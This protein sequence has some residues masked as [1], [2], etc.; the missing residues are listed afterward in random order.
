MTRPGDKIPHDRARSA[1]VVAHPDDEVLWFSGVLGQVQRIVLCFETIATYPQ[2]TA[3]RKRVLGRYPIAGV[4]SL[5][6]TESE[7]FNGADWQR[8][9]R[10]EFGL[11][12]ERR[13]DSIR[14]FSPDTYRRN[15][16]ELRTLLRARLQGIER[17]YTH[18]P[19]GEYGHEEHVQVYA[20]VHSLQPELGFELRCSNYFSNK[21]YALMRAT[22]AETGFRYYAVDTNRALAEELKALYVEHGCWTWYPDYQWPAHECFINAD[23]GNRAVRQALPLNF[24]AVEAPWENPV[25]STWTKVVRRLTSRAQVASETG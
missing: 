9:V 16:A 18:N 13:S 24:V 19:W 5:M 10:T 2:W 21:S 20:A 7:V 14:G 1:L 11:Q 23:A 8:P 6:L 12:V 22:F 15:Y 25:P 17:V 3:G 4:E